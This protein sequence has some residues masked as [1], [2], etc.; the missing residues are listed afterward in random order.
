M[1]IAP[2]H[3]FLFLVQRVAMM[4][5]SLTRACT[6]KQAQRS[7]NCH[8]RSIFE[9]NCSLGLLMMNIVLP[10]SYQLPTSRANHKT[11]IRLWSRIHSRH[12]LLFIRSL[13]FL[14]WKER[15]DLHFH[16]V[17][18]NEKHPT[19]LFWDS[20]QREHP[21]LSKYSLL[22]VW[23]NYQANHFIESISLFF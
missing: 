23:G 17:R 21:I 13:S 6:S 3:R 7:S 8:G 4:W 18:H 16:C 9:S 2:C 11:S 15:G 5:S 19:L 10:V 12:A 22:C 1:A 14:D 20:E